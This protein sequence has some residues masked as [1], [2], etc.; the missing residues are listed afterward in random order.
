VFVIP[1]TIRREPSVREQS[2]KVELIQPGH[3]KD[4]IAEPAELAPD[5]STVALK[6]RTAKSPGPFNAPFI[7]RA[8]TIK[9]PRHV[10]EKEI[11]LVAP[12]Q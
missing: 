11:E 1:V 10:A 12:T 4:I 7:I 9:G 2:M 6:I 3:V 8:T 5:Q